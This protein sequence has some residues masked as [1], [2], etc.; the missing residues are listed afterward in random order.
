MSNISQKIMGLSVVAIGA[1]FS[2][3]N[4]QPLNAQTDTAANTIK[5][6]SINEDRDWNFS[7]TSESLSVKDDIE[8]LEEYSISESDLTD[9]KLEEESRRT[10]SRRGIKDYSVEAEVYTY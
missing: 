9:I 8:N 4:I 6:W 2:T 5:T 10:N 3:I 7:N 1:L